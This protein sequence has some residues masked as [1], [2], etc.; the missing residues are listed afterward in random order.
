MPLFRVQSQSLRAREIPRVG[1]G[2]RQ[3]KNEAISKGVGVAFRDVFPEALGKI[4]ELLKSNSCSVEQAVSYFR[5][6]FIY[7]RLNVFLKNTNCSTEAHVS[8][9]SPEPVVSWPLVGY[10][11]SRVALGTRM[12]TYQLRGIASTLRMRITIS[13]V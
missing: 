9:S 7:G 10:K 3:F 2:G 4:G 6:S 12:H 11:L 13:P 1:W 5:R 8:F